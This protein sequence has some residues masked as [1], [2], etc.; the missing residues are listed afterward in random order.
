M[1]CSE[2]IRKPVPVH[3]RP[4]AMLDTIATRTDHGYVFFSHSFANWLASLTSRVFG[5]G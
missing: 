4:T 3:R 1:S 5:A 2:T